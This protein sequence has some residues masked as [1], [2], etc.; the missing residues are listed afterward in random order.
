MGEAIEYTH[1]SVK[2]E[3][4]VLPSIN[5]RANT[6]NTVI[7]VPKTIAPSLS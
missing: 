5:R 7:N 4:T 2:Q 6:P 1:T 3:S